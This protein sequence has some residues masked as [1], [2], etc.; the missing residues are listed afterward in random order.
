[1]EEIKV[2][3]VGE[4]V[5]DFEVDV[6][7]PD[8]KDF[9]KIKF[10]DIFKKG[11]WLILYFYPADY[12]FVCPTELADI[13]EKYDE[14]KKLGAELISVSTDTHYV[15]YAWQQQEKLLSEIKYPMASDPT[16]II[17]KTFGVYDENSGLALRG[18]FIIDP[19]GKLLASEI[20]YFP[21]GRN[22]DELL[23]KLKA[24]KYTRENPTQ[25]CPAKWQP[26]KKTL[27]PGKDLVG[28]VGER[29]KTTV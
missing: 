4:K 7:L 3:K 14:I 18:T 20:N 12:T 8:K 5:Q 27:T 25:V 17:S 29:L 28:K 26:G 19:D 11:K 13:G 16:H 15:H 23:R 6:Y 2:L 24:F 9:G 22:S 1:M 21:V 10:S